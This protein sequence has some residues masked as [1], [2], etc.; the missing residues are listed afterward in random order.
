MTNLS[1]LRLM[2]DEEIANAIEDKKEEIFNLRFQKSSGQLE[3]TNMIRFAKR[4]LARLKTVQRER[5]LA[6]VVTGEEAD[7]G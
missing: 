7:N 6:A 5:V 1:A 2:S 4:D 3:N